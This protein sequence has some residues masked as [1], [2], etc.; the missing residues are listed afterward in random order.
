MPPFTDWAGQATPILEVP[1]NPVY[2]SDGD[3]RAWWERIEAAARDLDE[4]SQRQY[5]FAARVG[6]DRWNG[7]IPRQTFQGLVTDG[8]TIAVRDYELERF[9]PESWLLMD[10]GGRHMGRIVMPPNA[11]LVAIDGHR[12][13]AIARDSMDVESVLL[14]RLVSGPS[15]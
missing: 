12:M 14:L 5:R 9:R 15:R 13:A 6:F 8:V 4:E 1:P 7:A 3:V 10:A 11:K 2:M